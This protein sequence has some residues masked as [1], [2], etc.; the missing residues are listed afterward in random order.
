MMRGKLE[1]KVL[2]DSMFEAHKFSRRTA[3]SDRRITAKSA[4]QIWKW[5]KFLVSRFSGFLKNFQSDLTMTAQGWRPFPI[6]ATI[7]LLDLRG[8]KPKLADTTANCNP[9][10]SPLSPERK[11]A[12]AEAAGIATP[13]IIEQST[14]LTSPRKVRRRWIRR[15]TIRVSRRRQQKR[16]MMDIDTQARRTGL[17]RKR[18]RISRGWVKQ[19]FEL[20]DVRGET[21]AAEGLFLG[22]RR[23]GFQF[24]ASHEKNETSN[25][26]PVSSSSAFPDNSSCQSTAPGSSQQSLHRQKSAP[27]DE[28]MKRPLPD[29]LVEKVL[30][31]LPVTSVFRFRSVCKSWQYT[32]SGEGWRKMLHKPPAWDACT[33]VFSS[34]Q[35]R[36]ECIFFDDGAQKWSTIDL[37]F[38]PSP[39]CRLLAASGGLLCLCFAGMCSCLYI[40]NPITKTWRELPEF[41]YKRR[42]EGAMLVHL[43]VDKA[44]LSYKVIVIGY[45]SSSSPESVKSSSALTEVYDSQT[46][47]WTALANIPSS[48]CTLAPSTTFR[49][50]VLYCLTEQPTG[51]MAF[52]I[53]RKVWRRLEIKSHSRVLCVLEHYG[54]I[55]IVARLTAR[56]TRVGIWRL[57]ETFPR[58][59]IKVALMPIEQ[60]M[61]FLLSGKFQ[62]FAHGNF[63]CFASPRRP[64]WLIFDITKRSWKWG[65]PARELDP[66]RYNKWF[67]YEPRLD[68]SA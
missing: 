66:D 26:D 16:R 12:Q 19:Q 44:T 8:A 56:V 59:W 39:A 4:K 57:R 67:F 22:G 43:L 49:N 13:E 2:G 30:A 33:G 51:L 62:C 55:L 5:L 3:S 60:A 61:Y 28:T 34:K 40:C 68:I 29:E 32:L 23:S 15:V 6:M 7:K 1:G 47:K 48:G 31:W 20:S 38:L 17:T 10:P 41:H 50:D 18:R 35:G 65:T 9:H 46:D 45:P 25:T 53:A 63:I 64:R 52:N 36:R 24:G 27:V 58:V 37:E 42:R 54:H 14:S 21:S 11:K